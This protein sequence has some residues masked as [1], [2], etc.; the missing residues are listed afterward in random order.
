M[1]A[2]PAAGGTRGIVNFS[3][4]LSTSLTPWLPASCRQAFVLRFSVPGPD[5]TRWS[6]IEH[7]PALLRKAT[8]SPRLVWCPPAGAPGRRPDAFP[9]GVPRSQRLRRRR[10]APT[11][12]LD[13]GGTVPACRLSLFRSHSF[14]PPGRNARAATAA[15]ARSWRPHSG[16]RDSRPRP[17]YGR[18]AAAA[19]AFGANGSAASAS[20]SFSGPMPSMHS[21]LRTDNSVLCPGSQRDHRGL[22]GLLN[23]L[24]RTSR[25]VGSAV[26]R[27]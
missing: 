11:L 3:P 5:T 25:L 27:V 26:V 4:F 12:P 7:T 17:S 6:R 19:S 15:L 21:P 18:S 1:A 24:S 2:W 8:Q 23:R 9:R 16:I 20:R 13:P 14:S 10:F 22:P